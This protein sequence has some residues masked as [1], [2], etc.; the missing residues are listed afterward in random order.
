MRDI[1]ILLARYDWKLLQQGTGT[2]ENWH[3]A[4]YVVK[5]VSALGTF[6]LEV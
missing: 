3:V 1:A 6:V 4:K 2:E 5:V